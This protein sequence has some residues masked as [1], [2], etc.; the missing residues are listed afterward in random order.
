MKLRDHVLEAVRDLTREHGQHAF[1]LHHIIGEIPDPP[2]TPE[3]VIEALQELADLG[4]L[5]TSGY[6]VSMTA[7]L[8]SLA[9][10]GLL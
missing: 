7:T 8:S 1:G 10:E 2:P 6:G 9:Y 4:K 5:V 3:E